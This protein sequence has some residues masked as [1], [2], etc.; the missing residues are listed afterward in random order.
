MS[1]ASDQTSSARPNDFRRASS[2]PVADNDEIQR[3]IST[4]HPDDGI[5]E[6]RAIY[7]GG[8]KRVDAGYFDAAHRDLLIMEAIRLNR[9]G[10]GVY[11]NLNMLDG[12]LLARYANRIEEWAQ[13][14]ATDNNIMRRVWL[15]IDLDPQRPKDTSATPEQLAL[16]VSRGAEIISRLTDKGWPKPVSAD[17]GNGLHFLYRIDLPNDEAHRDLVK[18]C[19]EALSAQF[20]DE[21][22]K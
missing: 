21:S 6:L 5:I 14:T 22:V 3:A 18:H 13:S 12:Q 4:L 16:A 8:R 9:A 17:S 11:V 20:D 10:A 15:L 7:K 19:L 2:E 1:V